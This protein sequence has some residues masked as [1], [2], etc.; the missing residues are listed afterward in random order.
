[1]KTV[2]HLKQKSD[3][4]EEKLKV[5]DAE[6][7]QLK[8]LNAKKDEK[9]NELNKRVERNEKEI[10]NLKTFA[11]R[12]SQLHLTLSHE[13]LQT[14]NHYDS[15][16]FQENY[17]RDEEV[18]NWNK[19][20]Q[21]VNEDENE[22]V[23]FETLKESINQYNKTIYCPTYEERFQNFCCLTPPGVFNV[24]FLKIPNLLTTKNIH[25]EQFKNFKAFQQ[26]STGKVLFH[27][28]GTVFTYYVVDCLHV[29]FYKECLS[30]VYLLHKYDEDKKLNL[31][32]KEAVE[33]DDL[34]EYYYDTSIVLYFN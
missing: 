17:E 18:K 5:K 16:L 34:C 11:E 9:L 10:I 7:E 4:S 15:T 3:E 20:V 25:I 24:N 29:V 12:T 14:Y 23:Y 30:D 33:I 19:V 1:M 26:C 6:I 13:H 8:E 32:N 31:P 22:C 21:Q 28:Y 2:K 27:N